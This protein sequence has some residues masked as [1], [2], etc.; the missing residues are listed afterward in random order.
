MSSKIYLPLSVAGIVA[1]GALSWELIHA[2][3]RALPTPVIPERVPEL[4][5][6]QPTD[7]M[8]TNYS[9][10][11]NGYDGDFDGDM[12]IDNL[13]LEGNILWFNKS[14]NSKPVPILK[15]NL[16]VVAYRVRQTGKADFIDFFDRSGRMYT[17]KSLG[18][19]A[20]GRPYFGPVE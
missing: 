4:N 12:A 15:V 20:Q 16:P 11:N 19:D 9:L 17:Q 7:T 5:W 10:V 6:A 3:Q 2:R 18:F 13:K 1:M 8:E 14:K